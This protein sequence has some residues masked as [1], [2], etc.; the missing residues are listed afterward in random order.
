V[1]GISLG[2]GEA[3]RLSKPPIIV[4]GLGRC[5]RLVL[6]SDHRFGIG[7]GFDCQEEEFMPERAPRRP[8][9]DSMRVGVNELGAAE[10]FSPPFLQE[11]V[12]EE[13]PKFDVCWAWARSWLRSAPLA[14]EELPTALARRAQ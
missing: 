6:G 1:V 12:A 9:E 11:G 4:P 7:R 5:G 3:G 14:H 13:E 2:A 10:E 8:E